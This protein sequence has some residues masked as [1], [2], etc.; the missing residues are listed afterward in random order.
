MNEFKEHMELSAFLIK[1]PH[2]EPLQHEIN[3][4]LSKLKSPE[5]RLYYLSVAM[6]DSFYDLK[7]K[8]AELDTLL[9]GL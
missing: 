9:K 8:L 6:T 5:D 1:N 4:A 2:L 7:E 3:A